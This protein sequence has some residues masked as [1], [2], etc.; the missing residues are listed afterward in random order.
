MKQVPES[1]ADLLKDETKA[2]AFLA[3]LMPDG[4][5]QVT[6]LWFNTDGEYI[7]INSAKGRVKDENMRARPEVAL[8]IMDTNEPYRYLQI[9]GEVVEITEENAD[10]HIHA[11]SQK[12]HGRPYTIPEGQVRVTYKI[13]PYG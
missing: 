1:M 10:A 5:P 6:P 12:Y 3:T 7:L 13:R 4:S 11:L 2:M 8:V 9:R